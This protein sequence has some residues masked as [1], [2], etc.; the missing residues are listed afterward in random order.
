[1]SNI[2]YD[3]DLHYEFIDIEQE[4]D[5]NTIQFEFEDEWEFVESNI[6]TQSLGNIGKFEILE[7]LPII[8]EPEWEIQEESLITERSY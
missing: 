5:E 1:M 3:Y 2:V 6:Y 8:E 7:L 4:I